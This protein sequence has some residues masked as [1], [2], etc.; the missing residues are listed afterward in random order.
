MGEARQPQMPAGMP[1][2]LR[3]FFECR[4]TSVVVRDGFLAMHDYGD[5]VAIKPG[6]TPGT[7]IFEMGMLG[8]KVPFPAS[9]EGGHQAGLPHA[10]S[11]TRCATDRR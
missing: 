2:D 3:A 1:E 9:I 10:P 8:Q 4:S 6:P 11:C 5:D 7:A